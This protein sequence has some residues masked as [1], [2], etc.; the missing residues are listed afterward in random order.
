[1]RYKAP[2]F[3]TFLLQYVLCQCAL[4]MRKITLTFVRFVF[5]ALNLRVTVLYGEQGNKTYL[6]R[7]KNMKECTAMGKYSVMIIFQ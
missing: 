2:H 3:H 6:V 4:I 7:E 5:Q 1:M